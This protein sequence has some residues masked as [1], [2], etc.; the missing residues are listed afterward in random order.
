MRHIFRCLVLAL[1]SL[2]IAACSIGEG[3]G[4]VN[5]R[6]VALDGSTDF[7]LRSDQC[8]GLLLGVIA[9]FTDGQQLFYSSRS[10]FSLVSGNATVTELKNNSGFVTSAE[11]VPTITATAGDTVTVKATYLSLVAEQTFTYDTVTIDSFQLEPPRVALIAGESQNINPVLTL[12][13]GTRLTGV[14][15]ALDF[16]LD[17]ENE[18]T[19]GALTNG[20]Q[21]I[22]NTTTNIG[23]STL[24]ATYCKRTTGAERVATVNGT[25]HAGSDATLEIRSNFNGNGPKA[26]DATAVDLPNGVGTTVSAHLKLPNNFERNVTLS[27]VWSSSDTNNTDCAATGATCSARVTPLGGAVTTDTVLTG[28]TSITATIETAD[29]VTVNADNPLKL[30]ISPINYQNP[31]F[32]LKDEANQDIAINNAGPTISM[33]SGTGRILK[34]VAQLT[35]GSNAAYEQV[36][37]AVFSSADSDKII[38]NNTTLAA[39][40]SVADDNI[41]I[42]VDTSNVPGSQDNPVA[43]TN[44]IPSFQ[45]EVHLD[46]PTGLIIDANS[47]NLAD[48]TFAAAVGDKAQLRSLLQFAKGDIVRTGATAWSSSDNTAVAVTNIN[49]AGEI[50]ILT[51][52]QTVITAK[53]KFVADDGT[54]S[55]QTSTI[56]IN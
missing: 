27:A 39:T 36:V 17:D 45:A 29:G 23:T 37:N 8:E 18:F 33:A 35:N 42:T 1:A 5:I 43:F 4:I 6:I 32:K 53:H 7:K 55:F 30:N 24:T 31:P 13:D 47:D 2:S 10:S 15:R 38:T 16:E 34:F 52:A 51:A 21:Q 40:G 56:T 9:T 11:L 50:T 19:L 14:A 22:L 41:V 54:E 48:A 46:A 28:E 26:A 12:S 49:N 20:G 3:N 44:N 25:N